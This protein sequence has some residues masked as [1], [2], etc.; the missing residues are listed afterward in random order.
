MCNCGEDHA[1]LLEFHQINLD[2]W[3]HYW[4]CR[5]CGTEWEEEA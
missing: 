2:D 3:I 1:E 5:L 4:I